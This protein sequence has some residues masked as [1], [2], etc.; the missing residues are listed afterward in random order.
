[1]LQNG[2]TSNI[3]KKMTMRHTVFSKIKFE[4]RKETENEIRE[5]GPNSYRR[6]RRRCLLLISTYCKRAL[7]L[8]ALFS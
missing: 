7:R 1:M 4:N 2:T 3:D 8:G 6:I 5:K